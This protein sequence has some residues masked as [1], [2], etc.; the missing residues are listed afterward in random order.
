[1][2]VLLHVLSDAA[3]NIGVMAAAAIMWLTHY[4]ARFYAD[5]AAS[6]AI[7]VLILVS[8]LPIGTYPFSLPFSPFLS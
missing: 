1:M 5:P 2:G 3:N 8:S 4:E 7:A 6:M